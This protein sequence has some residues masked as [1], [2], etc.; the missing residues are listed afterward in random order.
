MH[1]D[2]SGDE[3]YDPGSRFI[4]RRERCPLCNAAPLD[5]FHLACLCTNATMVA[6]R[7]H[8]Q[9]EARN[10]LSKIAVLLR[11]A[12]NEMNHDISSLCAEASREATALDV[13]TPVGRFV[14]FRLVVMMP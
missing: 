7:T 10:L 9:V 13:S 8:A 2:R 12:H 6:W 1:R 4:V 14:L 3:D 11:A 5:P